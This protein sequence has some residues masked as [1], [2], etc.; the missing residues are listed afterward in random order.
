MKISD[1]KFG[2]IVTT[3]NK[4]RHILCGDALRDKEDDCLFLNS[5][6]ENLR[7]NSLSQFDIMK[8][9]RYTP[10]IK[11]K[12]YYDL[13]TIYERKE[14]ILDDVEKEY[15][16]GVIEPFKDIINSIAKYKYDDKEFITV[17]YTPAN[18]FSLP[19]FKKGTMY[20]SM[21]VNRCYTIKK[22]GL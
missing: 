10:S 19:P 1:L 12:G 11:Y 15:L 2:D 22:L 5:Y 20:K 16:R 7:N 14:E 17:Y 21:E 8:V 9:Q 18:S 6:N 3:R 4:E 13:H